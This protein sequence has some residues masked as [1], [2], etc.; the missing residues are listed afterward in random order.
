MRRRLML[1][2]T[3][4]ALAVATALLAGCGKKLSGSLNSDQPPHTVIFVQGPVDSVNHLAHLFW[5][6]TDADGYV[7]GYQ[8]KFVNPADP[9]TTHAQWVYTSRTDSLFTVHSPQGGAAPTL[10]VRAVDNKGVVDPHPASES[11]LFRNTPPIVKLTTK[12]NRTDYSDTTF[13]SVTVAWTI[14]DPDGNAGAVTYR[15]WLDPLN[16]A[17][18]DYMLTDTT[19]F[20]V[21]SG[22][23]TFSSDYFTKRTL[24]VQ[25]ID[26]G[27]MAGNV[28][29]VTWNVRRPAMGSRARV[30]VLDDTY[31][32]DPGHVRNDSLFIN[33]VLRLNAVTRDQVAFVWLA[34]MQPFKSA[35][36]VAQ[37]LKEFDTVLWFHGY[38][39][40]TYSTTLYN[41]YAGI[42]PFL[43]GG[44]KMYLESMSLVQGAFTFGA[45]PPGF[46]QTYAHIDGV[47]SHFAVPE[48]LCTWSLPN[49]RVVRCPTLPDSLRN[50]YALGGNGSYGPFGVNGFVTSN[51]SEIFMVAGADSLSEVNPIPFP[52]ALNCPQKNNGRL[53]VSTYP[54]AAASAGVSG[55]P[56][57]AS[58][59]ATAIMKALGLDQ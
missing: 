16:G 15:V 59:V 36:D 7:V 55:Q 6:G 51:P 56:Q 37:T 8:L 30:L 54:L 57:R 25:A 42:G 13:A 9:D 32:S 10:Y 14:S 52:I 48:S 1:L 53:I 44:G 46:L 20:T 31:L 3:L 41:Y 23:F 47:F 43:D 26:D 12:P 24:H 38:A 21:P 2:V 29:S 22:K 28:D 18:I 4:A 34:T 39:S 58:A 35:A 49:R 50:V 17:P 33:A 5:Y 27:G 45:L 19:T 40:Q 11:F